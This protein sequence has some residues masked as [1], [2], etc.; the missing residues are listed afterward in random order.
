MAAYINLLFVKNIISFSKKKT[1]C[2][3]VIVSVRHAV[4]QKHFDHQLLCGYQCLPPT[5]AAGGVGLQVYPHIYFSGL[6]KHTVPCRVHILIGAPALSTKQGEVRQIKK[7]NIYINDLFN[8]G[9][10]K[11]VLKGNNLVKMEALKVK[12]LN[13]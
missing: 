10:I 3:I 9:C 4:S 6:I 13:V 2:E 11:K 12:V 1:V 7:K 8:P 5:S